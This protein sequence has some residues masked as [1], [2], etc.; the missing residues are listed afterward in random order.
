MT[1]YITNMT[2]PVHINSVCILNSNLNIFN[3]L[4]FVAYAIKYRWQMHLEISPWTSQ[5]SF[6]KFPGFCHVH[7][8]PEVR[9][10]ASCA[11]TGNITNNGNV[12]I[13]FFLNPPPDLYYSEVIYLRYV[14]HLCLFKFIINCF[15]VLWWPG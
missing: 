1:N 7:C 3:C 5:R 15:L 6:R 12:T 8:Q 9:T 13:A 14:N 2:P 11:E 4:Y 10:A